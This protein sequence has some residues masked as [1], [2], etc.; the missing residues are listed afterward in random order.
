V[1]ASVH[2]TGA[3]V[4]GDAPREDLEAG[5]PRGGDDALAAFLDRPARKPDDA[6]GGGEA[7]R[8][9]GLHGDQVNVAA[10]GGR[11]VTIM[12]LWAPVRRI[13]RTRRGPRACRAPAEEHLPASESRIA[14]RTP[15][16][17]PRHPSGTAFDPV[18]AWAHTTAHQ[19]RH[20]RA[21][22]GSGDAVA[23]GP[24]C[25][26]QDPLGLPSPEHAAATAW[27]ARRMTTVGWR[28][29]K[30]G[31]ARAPAGCPLSPVPCPLSPVPCPLSPVPCCS[32]I[33]NPYSLFPAVTASF[34][35]PFLSS[36]RALRTT[37]S[38]SRWSSPRAWTYS[39]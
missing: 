18:V 2:P 4:H 11:M 13:R 17:R 12:R 26:S 38:A 8:D 29:A 16:P 22:A 24:A 15:T 6:R 1:F 5:V 33:P 35:R 39:S 34:L 23:L 36:R 28:C 21:L 32:L 19:T 25:M 7:P 31:T 3:E 27:P 14:R 30:Q 20:T 10:Q 37:V 9:I